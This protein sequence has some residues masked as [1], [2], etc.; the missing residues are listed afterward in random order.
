LQKRR[1]KLKGN[2]SL[3]LSGNEWSKG[4]LPLFDAMTILGPGSGSYT[5]CVKLLGLLSSEGV[6]LSKK[7]LKVLGKRIPC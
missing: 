7:G 6:G 4:F 2:P 3:I 5:D 1:K